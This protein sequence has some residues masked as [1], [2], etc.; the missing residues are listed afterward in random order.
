MK[1]YLGYGKGSWIGVISQQ[2]DVAAEQRPEYARLPNRAHVD[3]EEDF[4][5]WNFA[6]PPFDVYNSWD[7]L[8][9]I[10]FWCLAKAFMLRGAGEVSPDSTSALDTI[11]KSVSNNISCSP[12]SLPRSL[13]PIWSLEYTK[14]KEF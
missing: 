11:S 8:I 4:K 12:K 7:D 5:L 13:C 14:R 6:N 2:M 9:A 3:N 10:Y 1:D